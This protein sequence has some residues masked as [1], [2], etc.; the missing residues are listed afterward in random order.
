MTL[1]AEVLTFVEK[2]KKY[3]ELNKEEKLLKKTIKKD[4]ENLQSLT[5]TTIESLSDNDIYLLLEKKWIQKIADS[6]NKLPDNIINKLIDTI[7]AIFKKYETTYL[8][9]ESE[10][11]ETENKLVLMIDELEGDEFD[12]K[13]LSEFKS[14]LLGKVYE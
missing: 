14:L 3:E 13:G 7:Q 11:K 9:I 8:D 1:E 5:K 6:L 2:L 12:L 4:A 10:I